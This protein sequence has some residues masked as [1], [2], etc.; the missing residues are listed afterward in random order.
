MSEEWGIDAAKK[1]RERQAKK[2]LDNKTL[3]EKRQRL[4]EQGP[5][6]WIELSELVKQKCLDFNEN[7][8]KAV[9]FVK[10]TVANQLEVRFEC[11][12]VPIFLYVSFEATS[13]QKALSWRYSGNVGKEAKN[14]AYPL[15]IESDGKVGFQYSLETLAEKMLD[16]LIGE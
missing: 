9:L 3:L 12:Q 7:Y 2:Q 16:G 13:S 15:L 14:S 1:L 8:G 10:D 6:L 4:E 5:N 11:D